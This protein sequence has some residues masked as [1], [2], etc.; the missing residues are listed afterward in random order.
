VEPPRLLV[1]QRNRGAVDADLDRV[2]A[3]RPAQE[4]DLGPFDE[5]EHHQPLN[6]GIGGL[7]GFDTGAIT[8]LEIRECQT[9]TPRQARK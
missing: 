6:G 8:G 5:A 1:A 7:D 3:E 2:A 4:H 9:S